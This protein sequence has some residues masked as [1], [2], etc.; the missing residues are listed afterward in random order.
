[1]AVSANDGDSLA[2]DGR[3]RDGPEDPRVTGVRAIIGH[4]EVLARAKRSIADRRR[5]DLTEAGTVPSPF[6]KRPPVH[7]DSLADGPDRVA[8]Q[9]HDP[10]HEIITAA[11]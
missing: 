10:E 2:N 11:S 9:C 7:E 6:A 5:A 8:G 1:M 3:F 4:H